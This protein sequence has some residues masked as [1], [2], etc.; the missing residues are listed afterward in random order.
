MAETDFF[1]QKRPDRAVLAAAGPDARHFLHTLLTNDIEHLA[2]GAPVYAALL[3]PQGKMLFD[4]FVLA[5]GPESFLIDCS[6]S[7]RE[8]LLKRLVLYRL[9]AKV[10]IQARDDLEV[11]VAAHEPE[12]TLAYQDPRRP[13]MGWR[14][15]IPAGRLADGTGYDAVRMAL[16]LAD[17]D[18]DLG[19]G[20]F[21]PHEANLDQL[22]G[23]SFSKGCYVGQEV[24]SRMQHRGTARSRILPVSYAA[25]APPKG[26][27]IMAGETVVGETLSSLG[28][29][30]LALIRLD[31]LAEATAPLL[32]GAVITRVHKP[33][34]AGFDVVGVES[35]S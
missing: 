4:M 19:T 12:G 10:T 30:G 24:V 33:G 35:E 22:H 34:W 18:A 32:T 31:R 6:A 16:G 23:V 11:G 13:E 8:D 15:F 20:Q 1:L 28:S 17:T 26:S 7:Q 2:P 29:R 5:E 9:R 14:C 25:P 21:F 3:S 27:V